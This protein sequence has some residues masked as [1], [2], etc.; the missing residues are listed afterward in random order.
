L[1]DEELKAAPARFLDQDIIAKTQAGLVRWDMIVTIGEPSDEGVL[2]KKSTLIHS[3]WHQA[4]RP[5]MTQC[6]YSDLRRMQ[7]PMQSV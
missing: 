4:L 3:S 7:I 5:R 1:S 6:F 2:V